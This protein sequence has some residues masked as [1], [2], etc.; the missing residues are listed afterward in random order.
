MTRRELGPAL[1]SLHPIAIYGA[2]APL[3][4]YHYLITFA[5]T[6]AGYF[7]RTSNFQSLSPAGYICNLPAFYVPLSF[8]S[9]FLRLPPLFVLGNCFAV[10]FSKAALELTNPPPD[11]L[12][13]FCYALSRSRSSVFS[14]KFNPTRQT[15]PEQVLKTTPNC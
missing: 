12:E 2:S 1:R 8:T 4:P 3:L 14:D 10:Y 7:L 11:T 9:D 6:L 13:P 15:P 5:T